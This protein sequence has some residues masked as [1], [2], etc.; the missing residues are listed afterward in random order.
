MA[1]IPTTTN[2]NNKKYL[3]AW[4]E[5]TLEAQSETQPAIIIF[6]SLK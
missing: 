2:S 5:R 6:I 1:A 4:I 3:E